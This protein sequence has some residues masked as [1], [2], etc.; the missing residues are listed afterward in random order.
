MG[1][2]GEKIRFFLEKGKH[3]NSMGKCKGS[4][5]IENWERSDVNGLS[6]LDVKFGNKLLHSDR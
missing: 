2:E 5:S 4:R 6:L 1:V 3:L